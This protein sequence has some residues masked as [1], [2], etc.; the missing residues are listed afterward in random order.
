MHPWVLAPDPYSLLR[1]RSVTLGWHDRDTGGCWQVQE[2]QL[3]LP[4]AQTVAVFQVEVIGP[5]PAGLPLPAQ[6]LCHCVNWVM[7]RL[8][9]VTFGAVQ[10]L[11]PVHALSARDRRPGSQDGPSSDT[12]WRLMAATG[13]FEESDPAQQTVVTVT[14]EGDSS[15]ASVAAEAV[16][17][18]EGMRERDG[19]RAFKLSAEQTPAEELD[20]LAAR[21]MVGRPGGSG[22]HFAA[23]RGEFAEFSLESTGWLAAFLAECAHKCGSSTPLMVTVRQ[24]GRSNPHPAH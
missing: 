14:L 12:M 8:G 2:A 22:G 1:S 7:D 5:I 17:C 9:S 6:A 13:V 4:S 21:P 24:A 18:L 19:I 10:L 16:R 23:V 20:P 15:V 11:L 3:G